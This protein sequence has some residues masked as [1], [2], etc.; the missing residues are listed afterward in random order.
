MTNKPVL[1]DV[2]LRTCPTCEE[3]QFAAQLAA[4]LV[5]QAPQLFAIVLEHD[6]RPDATCAAWGMAFNDH[7]HVVSVVGRDR[8]TLDKPENALHYFRGEPNTTPHLIWLH[9]SA[10]TLV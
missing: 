6:D 7:A 4:V 3:R 2:D 9:P 1:S 10:A 8:Y 5:E